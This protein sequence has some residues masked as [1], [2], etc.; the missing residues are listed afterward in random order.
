MPKARRRKPSPSRPASRSLTR[1]AARKTCS[2]SL[3]A[4]A[5]SER[6]LRRLLVHLSASPES[7]EAHRGQPARE[8]RQRR[9]DRRGGGLGHVEGD[10]VLDRL[11]A[12]GGEGAVADEQ[13]VDAL[14]AGEGRR[15]KRLRRI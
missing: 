4:S 3:T 2:R 12:V 10:R 7:D 13:A 8:Q 1:S 14:A 6:S 11:V 15:R 5:G 9:R